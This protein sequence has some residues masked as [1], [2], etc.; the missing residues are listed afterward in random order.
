MARKFET[1]AIRVRDPLDITLPDVEGEIILE[2]PE[3][4]QQVIV[5]PRVA[6]KSYE[7]YALEQSKIVEEIFKKSELDYLDLITDKSFAEP[8]AIFLKERLAI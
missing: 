7:Q 5:N 2:N 1:I 4:H 6:K 3:N 8:L